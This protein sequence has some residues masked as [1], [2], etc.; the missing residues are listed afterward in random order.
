MYG[1]H[2]VE[3]PWSGCHFPLTKKGRTYLHPATGT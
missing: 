3:F 2:A 1:F